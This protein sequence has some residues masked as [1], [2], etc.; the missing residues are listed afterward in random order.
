[1]SSVARCLGILINLFERKC[2]VLNFFFALCCKFQEC[3]PKDFMCFNFSIGVLFLPIGTSA[4]FIYFPYVHSSMTF[5]I[6]FGLFRPI[7]V[8][9]VRLKKKE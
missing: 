5:G 6:I 9:F 8:I 7:V 3:N 2:S 4:C 1:M